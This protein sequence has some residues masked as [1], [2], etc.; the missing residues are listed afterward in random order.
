MSGKAILVLWL[1]LIAS[2]ALTGCSGSRPDG[3]CQTSVQ[4]VC[5]LEWQSGN[6]V[7]IGGI[8]MRYAGLVKSNGEISGTTTVSVESWK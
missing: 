7:P 8:D 2:V 6:K 5:L 3:W 1:I 4:G